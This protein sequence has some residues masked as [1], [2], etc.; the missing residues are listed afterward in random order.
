MFQ[1]HTGDE[2]DVKHIWN[3]A[4]RMGRAGIKS[5]AQIGRRRPAYFEHPVLR[6]VSL[7]SIKV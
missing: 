1:G 5:R 2:K 6:T 4:V 7:W 3:K